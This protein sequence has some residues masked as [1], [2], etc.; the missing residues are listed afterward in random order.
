M[1]RFIIRFDDVCATMDWGRFAP[2]AQV[3]ERHPSIKPVIGVIPDNRDRKLQFQTG[4]PDFWEQVRQWHRCGWTITQ[5]GH[6]HVYTTRNGGVLGIRARSE[7]AGLAYPQQ[8]QKIQAGK[9]ILQ[10]QAVWQPY[11]MA[12]WHSFDRNTLKALHAL[13]FEAITDGWGV[14]PYWLDELTAVPQLFSTPIHFGA[15]IYTI[16]LHTNTLSEKAGLA[17]LRFIESNRDR[18]ISLPEAL[19]LRRSGLAVQLAQVGTRI[20]LTAGRMARAAIGS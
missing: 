12:P 17:M 1:S 6:T 3:F 7:F 20:L 15:G 2:F 14:Y 8:F 10:E 5:H 19:A 9:R 13:E 11:F 18:C 16:C 4:V